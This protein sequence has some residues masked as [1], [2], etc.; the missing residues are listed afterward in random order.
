MS[1]STASQAEDVAADPESLPLER[2]SVGRGA[3]GATIVRE[4]GTEG[5]TLVILL[6]GWKVAA[7]GDYRAWASHLARGGR[8]V[9]LPRY[10]GASTSPN[11]VLGNA[12][13]GVRSALRVV[14]MPSAMVVAG[15]SAGAALA[16]DY[17][18]SAEAE[19]LPVPDAVFAVY[20]GRAI[21]GYP[22]GIPAVDP[23]R[24]DPSTRLV[25][26]SSPTDTVVGELP[27][28][29]LLSGAVNVPANRKRLIIVT[30]P[31]AGDHYAPSG[32]D[33]AV[34]KAFWAPLDRLIGLV[35]EKQ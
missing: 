29:D 1:R 31:R 8:T 17:A 25:A 12:L 9:V 15:H 14:G 27:A 28:A 3:R 26:L 23:S 7:P 2:I 19:G 34:R 6:H 13:A 30:S 32:S 5:G 35:E 11:E 21:L 16:A 10:Q 22:E 4:Q 33:S 20:P 18:G 24:I